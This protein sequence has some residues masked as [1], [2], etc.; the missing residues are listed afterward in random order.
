M[1]QQSG[2]NITNSG[3]KYSGAA[4][5]NLE[6]IHE[7]VERKVKEWI[8]ELEVLSSIGRR[9]PHAAYSAYSAFTHGLVGKWQYIMRTIPSLSKQ[10]I[11]LEDAIR[12]KF[13]PAITG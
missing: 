11:P 13:I 8:S 9:D 12:F 2:V 10:L 4:L 3:R 6:F 5:G 1:F 7:Y